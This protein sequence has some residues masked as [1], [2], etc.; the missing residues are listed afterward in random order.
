MVLWYNYAVFILHNY[1]RRDPMK[2]LS[3]LAARRQ[4]IV[5]EIDSIKSMKKGTLNTKY[6][7]VINKNGDEILNG[8]YY[9]LT[10]KG[11]GN[12]TVSETITAADAS[13]VQEE[14]DNYKRFRQLTDE[15]MDICEELSQFADSE[16]EGKKN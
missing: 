16:D 3:Q 2:E 13:R 7:K 10:K 4:E 1:T 9:V 14:V 11:I 12:K 5:I 6:N 8:P 15:Y